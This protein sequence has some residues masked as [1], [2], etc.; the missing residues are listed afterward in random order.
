MASY[1]SFLL[2]AVVGYIWI[3]GGGGNHVLNDSGLYCN[4]LR[5]LIMN[6]NGVDCG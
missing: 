1:I 5:D 3:S 6:R 2:Y 4:A